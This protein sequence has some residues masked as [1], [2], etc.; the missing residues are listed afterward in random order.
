MLTIRKL[1]TVTKAQ[2][3]FKKKKNPPLRH[4]E[5]KKSGKSDAICVHSTNA[6]RACA[7]V[8]L[9]GKRAPQL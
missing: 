5:R 3:M 9:S 4:S 7:C 8:S 2:N 1:K 6:C